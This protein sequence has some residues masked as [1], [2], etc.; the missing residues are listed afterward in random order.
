[1][2]GVDTE[3]PIK[4]DKAAYNHRKA[5]MLDQAGITFDCKAAPGKLALVA[6]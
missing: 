5:W 6:A 1:V 2:F 3:R 4:D